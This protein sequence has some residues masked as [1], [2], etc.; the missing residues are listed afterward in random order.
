MIRKVLK[1]KKIRLFINMQIEKEKLQDN[2]NE[3]MS[4]RN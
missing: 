3:K 4:Q 1:I 2:Q